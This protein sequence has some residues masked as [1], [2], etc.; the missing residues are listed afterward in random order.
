MPD[1]RPPTVI[2]CSG[3][4]RLCSVGGSAR[5]ARPWLASPCLASA[6]GAS[7]HLTLSWSFS[8]GILLSQ[9]RALQLGAQLRLGL[10]GTLA[11]G[12]LSHWPGPRW[13]AGSRS[14]DL[15]TSAWSQEAGRPRPGAPACPAR[16]GECWV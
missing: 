10:A 6:R 14:G 13:G 3:W 16:A 9:T 11:L 12:A 5:V 4:V 7:A 8:F 15:S 1:A 2:W